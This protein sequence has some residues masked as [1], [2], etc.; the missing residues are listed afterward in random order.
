MCITAYTFYKEP[1]SNL[2]YTLTVIDTPGFGDTG[3]LTRDKQI[4]SQIKELF[5]IAG[6]E[7]ID[8]LH[9]IGFVTQAPLARLTPTQQYVFDAILSAFGKDVANNIILMITFADGMQPPVL[10]AVKAANVPYQA[11]F[12]FNNSA[13]FA[14]KSADDDFDRMF[15]KMGTKSFD[16]FFKMFS[17][18]QLCLSSQPHPSFLSSPSVP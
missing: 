4:V 11:F 5:S 2:P 3:G 6:E 16:E 14:S 12:K 1:G 13:L 15:W 10:D 9:G 7:G 18:A 8:V 17:S